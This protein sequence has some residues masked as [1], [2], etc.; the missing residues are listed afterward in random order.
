MVVM[1]YGRENRSEL[2][3]S[4]AGGG[5]INGMYGQSKRRTFDGLS[6]SSDYSGCEEAPVNGTL[7]RVCCMLYGKSIC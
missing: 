6:P 5:W 7:D 1:I 2:T 3:V 4:I